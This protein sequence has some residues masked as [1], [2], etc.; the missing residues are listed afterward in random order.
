MT[1]SQW[2]SALTRNGYSDFNACLGD[3]DGNARTTEVLVA[4]ATEPN[5]SYTV[6]DVTII[7]VSENAKSLA[8]ST[9]LKKLIECESKSQAIIVH[10]S[11]VREDL[12][13]QLCVVLGASA[14]PPSYDTITVPDHI[15]GILSSAAGILWIA[16]GNN[17]EVHSMQAIMASYITNSMMNQYPNVKSVT[18]YLDSP[19]S[20]N[21]LQE[22]AIRKV[23]LSSINSSINDEESEFAERNGDIMI[24]RYLADQIANKHL[25][26][27]LD[28]RSMATQQFKDRRRPLKLRPGSHDHEGAFKFVDD[29]EARKP[30]EQ[31]DVDILPEFFGISTMDAETALGKLVTN[32]AMTGECSGVI[33]NVG[34]NVSRNFK[35]GDRVAVLGSGN[36]RSM[37]RVKSLLVQRIPDAMSFQ[38]AASIPFAFIAAHYSLNVVAR[39]T[40]GES[41]LILSPT[42]NMGQAIISLSLSLKL[43]TFAVVGDVNK[44]KILM[45]R[46][47]LSNGDIFHGSTSTFVCGA[48]KATKGK[49]VNI[50][51]G[52]MDEDVLHESH[53]FVAPFGRLINLEDGPT[54]TAPRFNSVSFR[55]QITY[56]SVDLQLL[57]EYKP[58]VV[59]QMLAQAISYV[60]SMGPK[61][62]PQTQVYQLADSMAAC[63]KLLTQ[64]GVPKT[65]LEVSDSAEVKVSQT[66]CNNHHCKG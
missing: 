33:A 34:S 25:I 5:P 26:E 3:Y 37:I 51:I 58:E 19:S 6:P 7:L 4:S 31:D 39:A 38:T 16:D 60:D 28:P 13:G 35:I 54:N 27:A 49:G 43:R 24:F 46:F 8:R 61:C 17:S 9:S 12:S 1:R 64:D 45:D 63:K 53:S 52:P 65:L 14:Q 55:R 48:M 20:Q 59:G 30:I 11:Q 57:C 23:L 15:L 2:H 62:L 18:L 56:T 44:K 22:A 41:I 10:I 29:N 40:A 21:L 42:S 32:Q 36:L 66:S 47:G 50:V